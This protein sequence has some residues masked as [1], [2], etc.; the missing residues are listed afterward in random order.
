M[1]HGNIPI[2]ARTSSPTYS[3]SMATAEQR[4]EYDPLVDPEE[5]RVLHAALDSFR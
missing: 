5:R 1:Q 4:H 3:S 2:H